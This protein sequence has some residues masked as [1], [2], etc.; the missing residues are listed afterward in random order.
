MEV[1][2]EKIIYFFTDCPVYLR[3]NCSEQYGSKKY[4]SKKNIPKKNGK[5]KTTHGNI[6]PHGKFCV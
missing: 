6:T 4:K 2:D 1:K 3:D 5:K